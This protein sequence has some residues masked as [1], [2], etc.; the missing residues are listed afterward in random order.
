MDYIKSHPNI[1]EPFK[2]AIAKGQVLVEMT[3]EMV[4]A[5]WGHPTHIIK[6]HRTGRDSGSEYWKWELA[7]QKYH[8][9][10][11]ISRGLGPHVVVKIIG[12]E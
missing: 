10:L 3:P 8:P 1:P 2:K 5:A 12:A 4:I 7:G 11:E 9:T 6:A